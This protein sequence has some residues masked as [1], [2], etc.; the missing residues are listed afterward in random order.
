MCH[1]CEQ[2]QE[3]SNFNFSS[4]EL[5]VE[6]SFNEVWKAVDRA[7]C[8]KAYLEIPNEVLKNYNA[9]MLLHRFF[10]LC[11]VS[12]LNPSDWDYSNIK[13]TP[14]PEKDARDLLQNRCITLMCCVA[15]IYSSILN[16]RLQNYLENNNILVN[17]QNGFRAS[18]SCI[19]HIF[20]LREVFNKIKKWK[21]GICPKGWEGSNPKS[22]P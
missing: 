17:E 14:K 22:K 5:N 6:F 7:K 16:R 11:F 12:G 10:N 9:K 21:Y 15:K 8:G 20:V 4:D 3:F 2:Q 19:D 18:R 13:P 1:S